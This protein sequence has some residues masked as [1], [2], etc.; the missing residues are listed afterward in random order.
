MILAVL[1]FFTINT[2][3]HKEWVHKHIVSQA[4]EFLKVSYPNIVNTEM[5]NFMGLNYCAECDGI[6]YNHGTITA[7]AWRE[8]C[9]DPIFLNSGLFNQRTK[10]N[11]FWDA[12][13]GEDVKIII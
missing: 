11:H 4:Y 13:L 6:A 10:I 12:D 1:I 9:E 8:D 5:N 7:G 3:A 2:Y